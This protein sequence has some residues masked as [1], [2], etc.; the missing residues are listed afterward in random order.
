VLCGRKPVAFEIM[1]SRKS[2]ISVASSNT[3]GFGFQ[4]NLHWPGATAR[5]GGKEV[6]DDASGRRSTAGRTSPVGGFAPSNVPGKWLR[7]NVFL[8]I[9]GFSSASPGFPQYRRVSLAE[10]CPKPPWNSHAVVA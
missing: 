7:D 6:A 1:A 3:L 5:R 8:S 4:T 9:A 2:A 10:R